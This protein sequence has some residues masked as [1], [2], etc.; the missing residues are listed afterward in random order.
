MTE[1]ENLKELV[2][3]KYT[4]IALKG[5]ENNSSCCCSGNTTE[6]YNMMSEDYTKE[7]GYNADADLGLGCG[8]PTQ[9]AGIKLGDTVLDLGS[10]AGNDC[11]VARAEVG[12]IGKVIGVDFSEAM[13]EKARKNTEK[14]GYKNISFR[15]GDIEDLPIGGNSIDVV[16][17]N[18]VLN[19]LPKKDKIFHEIF[20]VLKPGGHFCI[21]DIV[22]VGELPDALKEV[23]E[24][25]A[26]CV[27]GAIQKDAYIIGIYSAGFQNVEIKKEKTI[28]IPDDILEKHLDEKT[29]AEFKSNQTGIFSITVTGFKPSA[30]CNCTSGCC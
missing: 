15:Q 28:T 27:S 18:C 9:F 8:L 26:G 7:E 1:R 12:E 25:Y 13:L 14:L 6:V 11:F 5:E 10:G 20:R 23:A 21:S 19:L 2:K 24:F 29:I 3:Q 16:I 22:L 30:P 4:E 17:S